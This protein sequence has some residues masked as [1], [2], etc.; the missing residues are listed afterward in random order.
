MSQLI[1]RHQVTDIAGP[2]PTILYAHGFGCNQDMWRRI[3]PAF[4]GHYRQVL[5]NYAGSGAD[6]AP[7]DRERYSTLAGYVDDLLAVCDALDL[8][9]GVHFVGHSVSCSIGWLAS[10]ARPRLFEQMILL[11]PSPCFLNYPPAYQGGFEREDLNGLLE[12]MD[13]NFIGWANYL[14]PVIAGAP[15]ADSTGRELAASFC[16]TDPDAARLFAR[17]TFFS[18]NR[19]DLVKVNVPSL[20]LQHR[21]DTLAP[22]A[23]GEFVHRQLAGSQLQVLDVT[24]HCA[25]MSHPEQVVAA[26]RGFLPAP[27][28]AARAA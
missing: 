22:M 7:T 17:A 26:M 15:Q 2:G 18:D 1:A 24:G 6:A 12:L 19:S 27:A 16:S 5:F 23:V 14:A 3:T 11:G 28:V 9:E 13:H 10:I 4:E 20:I 8:H 21:E 25:H